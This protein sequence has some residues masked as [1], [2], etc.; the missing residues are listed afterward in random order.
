MG[1]QLIE[2]HSF[3]SFVDYLS[4]WL[5]F[6]PNLKRKKMSSVTG[7]TDNKADSL[8]FHIFYSMS[9]VNKF[10]YVPDHFVRDLIPHNFNR[11]HSFWFNQNMV[12]H[13]LLACSLG[14]NNYAVLIVQQW[15]WL[16]HSTINMPRLLTVL[17]NV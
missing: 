10:A 16:D 14:G 3:L 1:V 2:Y 4:I 15:N 13:C 17:G 6:L 9:N 7:A 11:S 12:E 5:L 8:I